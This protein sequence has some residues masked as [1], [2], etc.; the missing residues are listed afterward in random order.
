MKMKMSEKI[1]P[2][3]TIENKIKYPT[4]AIKIYRIK[5]IKKVN[6]I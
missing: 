3:K 4:P 5:P 6:S 2:K 1:K